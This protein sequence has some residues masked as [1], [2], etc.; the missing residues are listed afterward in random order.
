MVLKQQ[1]G[2]AFANLLSA[3]MRSFLAILG[4]LVGTASVVALVSTGQ[5]ATNQALEQFKALG[6]DLIAVSM[7]DENRASK[8]SPANTLSLDEI[9]QLQDEVESVVDVAAYVSLYKQI[10]FAGKKINGSI[11]AADEGLQHVIKVRLKE[12]NFVS[13]LDKYEHYCVVGDKVAKAIQRYTVKPLVGQQLWLGETIY[14][15]IGVAKPWQENSFFIRDIN[16][17]VL[18]PIRGA[19]LLNKDAKISNFILQI[20]PN[21]DIDAILDKVKNFVHLNAP[22]LRVY[23][24]SPQEII[25]RMKKQGDIFTMLLGLIG[26]ISLLVGGIGVMNVMLVSVTERRREIGIRMAIGAKRKDIRTLFLVESVILALF[27]GLLG[28]LVGQVIA[29]VIAYFAKWTF[30]FYVLPP[31]IGFLVS[32]ATGVFF[33][34]YPAFRASKLDPIETLRYE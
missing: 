21:S 1:I 24:H 30:H 32:A 25:R 26:S 3:K 18:I 33:G 15:I 23:P 28:V 19:S 12:G 4:I 2:Q 7:F 13:F 22:D 11:I 6:T 27:G 5:L 9:K 10:S 29:V 17:S 20:K 34:F 14:T 16:K 8:P 31:V